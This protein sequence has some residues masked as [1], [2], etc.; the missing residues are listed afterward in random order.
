LA[1]ALS[2]KIPAPYDSKRIFIFL[3]SLDCFVVRLL[4][5]IQFGV[6]SIPLEILPPFTH[7]Q[8]KLLP[9]KQMPE[10]G[11]RN[12]LT[13]FLILSDSYFKGPIYGRGKDNLADGS[14][15]ISSSRFFRSWNG[16][17]KGEKQFERN[18]G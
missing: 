16:K 17:K 10:A 12:H 9:Q 1:P 18:S 3:I 5:M 11:I 13:L 15:Q 6:F 8:S 7:A 14:R 4:A 2:K